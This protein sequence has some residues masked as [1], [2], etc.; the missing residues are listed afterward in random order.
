MRAILWDMDG[1]LA[2]TE[3][4]HFRAWQQALAEY[5]AAYS[6]SAFLADFG[7]NNSEILRDLFG[8]AATP[9]L[10]K[11]I[12]RRKEEIFRSLL[13]GSSLH[14]MPGVDLWLERFQVAGVRQVV[15]SSGTMANI[16]ALVAT[17]GIGDYFMSLMSGYSLP[18]GKPH[19]AIFLNSS[20]AVGATPAECIVIEDSLAGI[21]AA[22]RAGMGCI[23]VGKIA[24]SSQLQRLLMAVDGEPCLS[25]LTLEGMAWEQLNG[26]WATA[27]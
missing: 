13:P 22:R 2:D 16:S 6:Y 11:R 3:E 25:A 19:P 15:S 9:D 24:G 10:I 8:A 17:L 23:A 18:R 27:P 7:R 26:L 12:S 14:L 21:E 4:I 20:A 5:D 1:T